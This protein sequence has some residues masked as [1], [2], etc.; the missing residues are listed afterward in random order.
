MD[1]IKNTVTRAELRAA[2]STVDD[3]VPIADAELDGQKLEELGGRVATV[4][5]FLPALMRAVEFGATSDARPL[6]PAMYTLA[7]LLTGPGHVG[8]PPGGSTRRVNHDLVAGRCQPPPTRSGDS[9]FSPSRGDAIES[10]NA[11]VRRAVNARGPDE[12][13][14]LK[15]QGIGQSALCSSRRWSTK[16]W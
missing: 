4:R 10:L 16:C 9:R 12:Q 5:T 15:P 14:A 8:C 2:L 13:A 3:L 6:L 7:D 11:R 1:L